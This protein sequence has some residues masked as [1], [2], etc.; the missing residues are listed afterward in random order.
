MNIISKEHSN[1]K[2]NLIRRCTRRKQTHFI[3]T[4]FVFI[5]IPE[6]KIIKIVNFFSYNIKPI[7]FEEPVLVPVKSCLLSKSN[8]QWL[9]LSKPNE[10]W[11]SLSNPLSNPPLFGGTRSIKYVLITKEP[12]VKNLLDNSTNIKNIYKLKYEPPIYNEIVFPTLTPT[13]EL[14]EFC[15]LN[16]NNAVCVGLFIPCL[17][18]IYIFEYV[19]LLSI[20][21][22][23]FYL[24]TNSI[25]ELLNNLSIVILDKDISSELDIIKLYFV[26]YYFFIFFFIQ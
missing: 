22:I 23:V 26:I 11:L 8:G 6:T 13:I 17:A 19:V 25:K 7:F 2:E 20:N 1:S 12:P 3:N 9:Y 18:C 5:Y 15:V 24:I 16:T 10:Q 14:I 4:N 21:V